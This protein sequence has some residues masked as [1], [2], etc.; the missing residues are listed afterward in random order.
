MNKDLLFNI[1]VTDIISANRLLI[2][3]V[4]TTIYRKNREYW[5]LI[6]KAHGRT[7][8]TID[9]HDIVSDEHHPVILS[10]GI[11]YSWKCVE[12]GECLIIDF[13]AHEL[14]GDIYA[15]TVADNSEIIR[16][17]NI[18]EKKLTLKSTPYKLEC[19]MLLYQA[20]IYI[21]KSAN[22]NYALSSKQ[23]LLQ[24]AIDYIANNYYDSGINNDFLARLCE[25]STVYFRKVFESVYGISSMKYLQNLR[26]EKAKCILASDYESI[27]QVA[28]S[29]GYNSIYHFSKM[30][31]QYT[32]SSPKEYAK[33]QLQQHSSQSDCN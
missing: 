32:G 16:F 4:G 23:K 20:L 5:A 3:P 13:D 19:K 9:G 21:L 28:E 31:K 10:K 33:N 25:I 12:P 8:Y 11:S 1:S 27:S 17:F 18:I 14:L 30:F 7:I 2:S 22:R 24:P 29:V 6:L 26:L 15:F